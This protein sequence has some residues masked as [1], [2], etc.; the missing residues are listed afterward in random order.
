MFFFSTFPPS[1]Y[2][3]LFFPTHSFALQR[4][5]IFLMLPLNSP[6]LSTCVVLSINSKEVFFSLFSFF[7]SHLSNNPNT[8]QSRKPRGQL[9]HNEDDIEPTKVIL[10]DMMFRPGTPPAKGLTARKRTTKNW[11]NS[12]KK[13]TPPIFQWQT[14]TF[15]NPHRE[16]LAMIRNT[17][18]HTVEK[19]ALSY[20]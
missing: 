16:T 1:L 7:L 18:T 2:L 6:L 19:G 10:N 5:L 11:N 17:I 4:P 15:P 12:V 20:F 13:N 8:S 9:P 14:T 3:F